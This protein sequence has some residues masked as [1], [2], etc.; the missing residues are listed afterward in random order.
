M[1]VSSDFFSI[2]LPSYYYSIKKLIH[3]LTLQKCNKFNFKMH[4]I[5]YYLLFKNIAFVGYVYEDH[6]NFLNW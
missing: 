2:L 1:T 5:Y 6:F 4:L 3:W